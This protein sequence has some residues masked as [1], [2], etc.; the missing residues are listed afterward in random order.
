MPRPLHARSPKFSPGISGRGRYRSAA[1]ASGHHFAAS[2]DSALLR[3]C[4]GLG[5]PIHLAVV[6]Q[7][8]P[9]ALNVV[10]VLHL[11]DIPTGSTDSN[12][13]HRNY[14]AEVLTQHLPWRELLPR[15]SR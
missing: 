8:D 5:E 3:R 7:R 9:V 2:K 14:R 4:T 1:I 10:L 12:E 15:N 11:I 13:L 6:P